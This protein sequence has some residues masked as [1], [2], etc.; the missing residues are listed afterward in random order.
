MTAYHGQA[1]GPPHFSESMGGP[2]PIREG[3]A[4]QYVACYGGRVRLGVD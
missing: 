4:C 2:V 3:C 1:G